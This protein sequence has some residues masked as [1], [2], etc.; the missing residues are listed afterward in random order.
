MG[1]TKKEIGAY[2][3]S[4]GLRPQDTEFGYMF[5]YD[6]LTFF[7]FWDDDDDQYLKLALPG[8]FDVNDNNRDDALVAVNEVNKEWKVIKAVVT[9]DD[10]WVAAEQFVD[11]DPNFS[12]I[13]PR[14]IK[15]LTQGRLSFY[16]HLK[17]L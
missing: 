5:E 10:V 17:S 2:L 14:T 6:K 15:I 1:T 13:V 12:D 4:E 11:K 9:D 3:A 7:V 8:I 16:D